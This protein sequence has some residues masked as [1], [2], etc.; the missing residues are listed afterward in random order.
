MSSCHYANP[1]FISRLLP[2]ISCPSLHTHQIQAENSAPTV[3]ASAAWSNWLERATQAR[4]AGRLSA[5]LAS[6]HFCLSV[7]NMASGVCV[8]VLTTTT[9]APPPAAPP[10]PLTVA[11]SQQQPVPAEPAA[12]ITLHLLISIHT[13]SGGTSQKGAASAESAMCRLGK[14]VLG[15]AALILPSLKCSRRSRN[16]SA[17]SAEQPA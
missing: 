9:T 5:R 16:Q 12:C 1:P 13:R 6:I 8:V 2:F 10:H 11:H 17:K 4:L 7:N 3:S 15:F 14:I